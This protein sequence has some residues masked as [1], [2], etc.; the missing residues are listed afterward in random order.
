MI[1]TGAAVRTDATG[2]AL[3]AMLADLKTFADGGLTDDEVAKS[4]SQA[5]GE[6]VSTYES[7][8]HMAGQ[9]AGNASL[10][11]PPEWEVKSSQRLE[12]ATKDDLG[13]LAKQYFA[14]DGAIIVV[15]GPRARVQTQLDKLGLPAPEIRDATGNIL[16]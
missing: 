11:L 4:R 10:G 8:E 2:D 12:A 6:L 3:G 9:L 1:I 5:R 7:L 13:R 16:K 14:P 15:V